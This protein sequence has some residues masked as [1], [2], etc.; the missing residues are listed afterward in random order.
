MALLESI[1]RYAN[2]VIRVI[3]G[4]DMIVDSSGASLDLVT[5]GAF[6]LFLSILTLF[7][8]LS[9]CYGAA[10]LSWC[11]NTFYGVPENNKFGWAL[12]CFLFPGFYYPFY[13]TSLDPVCGRVAQR[14][15]KRKV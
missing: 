9:N 14:G 11:Y 4:N 15:G 6:S 3:A 12:L 13:A 10:R 8:I 1:G 5:V 2:D 7:I